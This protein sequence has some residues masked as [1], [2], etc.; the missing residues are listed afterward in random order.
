MAG[1]LPV[2][3]FPSW[4]QLPPFAAPLFKYIFQVFG[5][6]GN[7]NLKQL[8]HFGLGQ[9]DGFI[10]KDRVYLYFVILGLIKDNFGCENKDRHGLSG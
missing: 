3:L 9:P 8:R 4:K 7:I 1:C 5:C 10:L 2:E 6:G